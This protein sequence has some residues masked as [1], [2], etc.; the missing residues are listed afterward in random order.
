MTA[1]LMIVGGLVLLAHNLWQRRGASASARRWTS[2][3]QGHL[4]HRSV[5]LVRPL[6]AVVVLAA[7]VV[8]AGVPSYVAQVLAVLV[9][10]SL[11]LLVACL[12]LPAPIPRWVQPAWYRELGR[13]E[14]SP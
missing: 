3:Y 6:V 2:S 10:L 13:G 9:V 5:L 14:P 11:I 4:K 7:G 12:I 8:A 1:T